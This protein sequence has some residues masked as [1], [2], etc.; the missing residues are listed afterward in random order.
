M[1]NRMRH[2]CSGMSSSQFLI[3]P[4]SAIHEY[5]F[6]PGVN[7]PKQIRYRRYGRRIRYALSILFEK[8]TQGG[9]FGWIQFKLSC[10]K[11]QFPGHRKRR[12]HDVTGSKD[13]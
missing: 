6:A 12:T 5:G 4:E 10:V 3:A 2:R 8:Q 1:S 9:M 11:R 7:R 13:K